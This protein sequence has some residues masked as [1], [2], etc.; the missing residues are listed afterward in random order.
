MSN[1]GYN[2]FM[3]RKCTVRDMVILFVALHFF[4]YAV[5]PLCYALDTS[6]ASHEQDPPLFSPTAIRILV[7]H[8]LLAS[9][10]PQ[11]DFLDENGSGYLLVRKNRAILGK[12]SLEQ[13]VVPQ[14]S[15][16]CPAAF[17][18]TAP[19]AARTVTASTTGF[20]RDGY[21]RTA[22]GLSPPA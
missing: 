17:N 22:S 10:A 1:L 16:V 13:D 11:F 20:S 12:H 7:W 6:P 3:S 18:T 15:S 14:E 4:V 5:S 9:A 2:C 19:S 21:F 8:C